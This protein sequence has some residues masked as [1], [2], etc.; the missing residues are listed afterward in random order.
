MQFP[1]AEFAVFFLIVY[2]LYWIASPKPTLRKLVLLG[3]SYFFYGVIE[4]SFLGLLIGV[5]ALNYFASLWIKG[6][7]HDP[8]AKKRILAAFQWSSTSSSWASLNT[9][10]SSPA[11]SIPF[12]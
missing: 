11:T 9:A 5:S 7:W 12:S 10:S 8:R 6:N 2:S 1:T 4:W 3:A